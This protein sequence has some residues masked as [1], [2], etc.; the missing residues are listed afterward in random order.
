ME[1]QYA[2]V[3]LGPGAMCFQK[4]NVYGRNWEERGQGLHW[5]SFNMEVRTHQS[6][7]V[8]HIVLLGL[9]YQG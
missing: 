1:E 9:Y 8:L 5:L 7:H 2:H 3:I 4:K 6:R